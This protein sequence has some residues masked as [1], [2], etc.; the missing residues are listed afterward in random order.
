MCWFI[1]AITKSFLF[2]GLYI[3]FF[4]SRLK[5]QKCFSGFLLTQQGPHLSPWSSYSVQNDHNPNIEAVEFL[6]MPVAGSVQRIAVKNP[7]R[8]QKKR[9]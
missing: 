6:G 1:F 2:S 8:C 5:K 3:G 7:K 9:P 4:L